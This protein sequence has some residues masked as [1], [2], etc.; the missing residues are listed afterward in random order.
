MSETPESITVWFEQLRRGDAEAAAK[1]WD[2]F[3]D[4]LVIASRAQMRNA[5]RRVADEEDIAAG[6]M[7]ALCVCA[8]RGKLPMID[9]RESLWRLL[10]AWTRHDIAD[11]VRADRRI[12][13]GGG[14]V[15]GESV[16]GSG[17]GIGGVADHN[18]APDLLVQI[19]EQYQQLLDTLPDDLLRTIAIRKMEGYRTPEIAAELGVTPRTIQRKLDLIRA[20][21][22]V[23]G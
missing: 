2:R 18:V 3:F 21:W 8:D 13:R 15:R 10:L 11:H 16:F 9:D 12:K 22:R 19:Q 7:A 14:D 23:R 17:E 5:N 6:V 4:R 20:H 1:L